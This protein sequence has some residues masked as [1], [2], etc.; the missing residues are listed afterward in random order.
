MGMGC[1]SGTYSSPNRQACPRSMH[2]GGILVAFCDGSVHWISDHIEVSTN[3]NSQSVWDKLNL[4]A[5]R[6]PIDASKY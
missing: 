6:L 2:A 4:A 5:D 1:Y 3:H